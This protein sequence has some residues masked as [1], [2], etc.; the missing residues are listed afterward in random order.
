MTLTR[1]RFLETVAAAGA[2]RALHAQT[3]VPAP[4]PPPQWGGSVVD[5]HLHIR[6]DLADNITHMDGCGVSHAV[7]LARDNS[8]EALHAAQAKYPGRLGWAAATNIAAPE[9]EALLTKAARDGATGFGELK[10]HLD[11]DGPEF[12]RMYALAADLG[13]PILIHFQE[14]PHFEGEGVWGTGFARFEAVLKA[15]PRTTFVGHADAFWANVDATYANKDAYP[16]G[17]IVRGGLTD[18]LLGDYANLFGDL[19]ANS[20]NN[21]LSRDAAFTADFLR[22]HQDKLMFGS[23]CS[24]ADGRGAGV[25]Q[26]NNPAAARLA[27]KCVARETLTLLKAS[28]PPAVFR[29]LTWDNARRIYKL[30]T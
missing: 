7:I 12:K 16:T 19:S 17:P 4:A 23:D 18:K 14:V 11:A 21:A 15:F 13:V 20:G 28:T 2:A 8:G 1:R 22:R 5:V 30:K 29:K 24:C 9:A 6:R 26:A 3:P 10:F 27:G 25:A